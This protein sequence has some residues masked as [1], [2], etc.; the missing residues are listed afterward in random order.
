MSYEGLSEQAKITAVFNSVRAALAPSGVTVIP[1]VDT[2][3]DADFL[4]S[5]GFD[6]SMTVVY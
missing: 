4:E 6:T 5:L 2:E 1:A 3:E